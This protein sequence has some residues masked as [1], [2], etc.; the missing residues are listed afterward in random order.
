MAKEIQNELVQRN[1]RLFTLIVEM[2]N[3][4]RRLQNYTGEDR[5]K[6]DRLDAMPETLSYL[7]EKTY[8]KYEV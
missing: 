6:K 4:F 2:H 8:L 5:A 1:K 7:D 3:D